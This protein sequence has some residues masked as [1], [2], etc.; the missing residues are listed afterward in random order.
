MDITPN[1]WANIVVLNEDTS[2]AVR[3]MASVVGV[4]K[5]GV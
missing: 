1:K 5:S 3:G 2:V 4:G